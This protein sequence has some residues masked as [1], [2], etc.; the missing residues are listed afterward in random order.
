[1]IYKTIHLQPTGSVKWFDRNCQYC[2][3]HIPAGY[4]HRCDEPEPPAQ[5]GP[6]MP[7]SKRETCKWAKPIDAK[8]LCGGLSASQSE[9]T[10]PV[11]PWL[12]VGFN[13]G[14]LDGHVW[15]AHCEHCPCHE[16]KEAKDA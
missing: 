9:C 1:M 13:G 15:D 4:E 8:F 6:R 3:E 5:E 7:E 2:G 11:V 16:P 12:R 10:F 14:H